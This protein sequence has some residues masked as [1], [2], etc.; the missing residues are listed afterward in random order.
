MSAVIT[1]LSVQTLKY[2]LCNPGPGN[3]YEQV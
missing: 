3:L 2:A 1:P